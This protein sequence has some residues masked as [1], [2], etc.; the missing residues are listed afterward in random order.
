MIWLVSILLVVYSPNFWVRTHQLRTADINNRRPILKTSVSFSALSACCETSVMS[1][2]YYFTFNNMSLCICI[3]IIH[4][5]LCSVFFFDILGVARCMYSYR[6]VTVRTSRFGAWGLTMNTGNSPPI[7]K[8][9]PAVMQRCLK[10]ASASRRTANAVSCVLENKAHYTMTMC[11]FW[12]R[13]SHGLTKVSHKEWRAL[14]SCILPLS[15]GTNPN[16]P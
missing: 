15:F 1:N 8:G 6:T 12:T 16:I 5:S 2:G 14:C 3:D 7:Q 4:L 9:A 13:F 11:W 10:T